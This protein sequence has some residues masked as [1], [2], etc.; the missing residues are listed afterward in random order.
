MLPSSFGRHAAFRAWTTIST[1]ACGHAASDIATVGSE[2][3]IRKVDPSY[4][5]PLLRSAYRCSLIADAAAAAA[6]AAAATTWGE[7]MPSCFGVALP[8][9][10]SEKINKTSSLSYQSH[11]TLGCCCSHNMR[12][13]AFCCHHFGFSLF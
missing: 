11:A 12:I 1:L 6:A 7:Y 4:C 10:L 9:L 5:A 8:L 3:N 2:P 13:G